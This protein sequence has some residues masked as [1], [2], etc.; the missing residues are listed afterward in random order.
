MMM[1]PAT[2]IYSRNNALFTID[3][4]V[5]HHRY[6]AYNVMCAFNGLYRLGTQLDTGDDTRRDIYS[7][8]ATDGE[9][10]SLMIVTRRFEGTAEIV[11]SGAGFDYC[12]VTRIAPGGTRGQGTVYRSKDI[13]MKD[14]RATLPLKPNEVYTVAFFN[15]ED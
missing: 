8:A 7:L 5:T 9:R 3:D 13:P 10:A 2:D 14:G 15:K 6:A 1:Y 4:H 11:L 12:S